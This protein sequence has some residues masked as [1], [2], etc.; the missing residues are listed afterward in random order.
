MHAS[1]VK[2]SI[3]CGAETVTGGRDN[4]LARK[5]P[6]AYLADKSDECR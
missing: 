1:Q 5:K 2:C 4:P 6:L 3:M